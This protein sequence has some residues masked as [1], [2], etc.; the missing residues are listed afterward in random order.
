M[1]CSL[2]T[3]SPRG[4]GARSCSSRRKWRT[5]LNLLYLSTYFLW[6]QAVAAII[7]G[8]SSHMLRKNSRCTWRHSEGARNGDTTALCRAV[9]PLRLGGSVTANVHGCPRGV[10]PSRPPLAVWD[11]RGRTQGSG[12]I[13]AHAQH[14]MSTVISS[15]RSS[16]VLCAFLDATTVL[17]VITPHDREGSA[18]S[19]HARHERAFLPRED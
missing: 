11:T 9:S 7:G 10:A 15:T 14:D 13:R 3:P 19:F 6:W 17:R 12:Q 1:T 18:V 4:A 8:R 5:S 2:T 16:Q